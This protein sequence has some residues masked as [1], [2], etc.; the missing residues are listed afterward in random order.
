MSVRFDR[1][2]WE[3]R[4]LDGSGRKRAKRFKDEAAALAFDEALCEVRPAE[5]RADTAVHG[6]QGNIYPYRTAQGTYWRFVARRSN[7]KQTSKRGFTSSRAARGVPA[8]R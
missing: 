3:V 5:R 1:G 7:G 4:W 6:S 8:I 2:G